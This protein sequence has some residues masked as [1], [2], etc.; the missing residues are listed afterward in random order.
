[1]FRMFLCSML[2]LAVVLPAVALGINPQR[3]VPLQATS[4][5]PADVTI[6]V[7]DY[8][9]EPTAAVVKPGQIV[10]WINRHDR[11]YDLLAREDLPGFASGTLKPG[12]SWT[13]RVPDELAPGVY[14]YG[15]RLRPRVKGTLRVED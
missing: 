13:Y 2:P 4:T 6:V 9:F 11:D 10:R 12:R 1:M 5:R 3:M 15:C 7:R 8:R 14:E